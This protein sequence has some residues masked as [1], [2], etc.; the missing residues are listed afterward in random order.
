MYVLYRN[1]YLC[2]T[3][4]RYSEKD[5]VVRINDVPAGNIYRINKEKVF[6]QSHTFDG[7]YET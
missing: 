6:V 3:G 4:I 7:G 5:C 2:F 1:T